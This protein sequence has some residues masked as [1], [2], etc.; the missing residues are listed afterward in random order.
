MV[1]IECLNASRYRL[2]SGKLGDIPTAELVVSKAL[3]DPKLHTLNCDT[4]LKAIGPSII[5]KCQPVGI[6]P[7][8]L[9]A[10]CKKYREMQATQEVG[11]DS[12][13]LSQCLIRPTSKLAKVNCTTLDGSGTKVRLIANSKRKKALSEAELAQPKRVCK[14]VAT[15]T[16]RTKASSNFVQASLATM[17]KRKE[18][19][20][21]SAQQD[22]TLNDSEGSASKHTNPTKTSQ[23][24]KTNTKLEASK[25]RQLA[26]SAYNKKTKE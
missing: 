25:Q 13:K 4:I 17:L 12:V 14:D 19:F 11:V 10:A 15:A 7:R 5:Q 24:P 1:P 20:K 16:K 23:N 3:F 8:P 21:D 2:K 6:D 18:D 22:S 9:F 26:I